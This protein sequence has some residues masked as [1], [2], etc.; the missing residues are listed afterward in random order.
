MTIYDSADQHRQ[1]LLAQDQA[2]AAAMV[3]AY[4]SVKAQLQGDLDYLTAKLASADLA[5]PAEQKRL[6]SAIFQD[7]RVKELLRQVELEIG[8]YAQ[9]VGGTTAI[10]QAAAVAMAQQHTQQL[11]TEGMGPPP[12]GEIS[13]AHLNTEAV[14]DLVGFAA[15]GS[16]LAKLLAPLGPNAADDFRAIIVKT[17]GAGKPIPYVAKQVQQALGVP[18]ARA[19][20]IVRTETLRAYREA[21]HRTMLVNQDVVKGWVWHSALG[22][23]TCASCWALHGSFHPLTERLTDHPNGRCSPVPITRTWKELGFETDIAETQAQVEPGPGLFAKLPLKQQLAIVGPK[24]LA[25]LQSNDI[26]LGD[27][28]AKVPNKDWGPMHRE[29]TIAESLSG[30]YRPKITYGAPP[31][32]P[33][34]PLSVIKT[35]LAKKA[36]ERQAMADAIAATQDQAKAYQK[37]NSKVQS[38]KVAAKKA[39][40]TEP[41]LLKLQAKLDALAAE[42]A[43][44]PKAALLVQNNLDKV[45]QDLIPFSQAA[46]EAAIIADVRG[47]AAALKQATIDVANTTDALVAQAVKLNELAKTPG[48]PDT[49]VAYIKGQMAKVQKLHIR[50]AEAETAAQQQAEYQKA[51]SKVQ[52]LKA[53]AKKAGESPESLEA[54]V[55]QLSGMKASATVPKVQLLLD[56]NLATAID[57][58]NAALAAKKQAEDTELGKKAIEGIKSIADG[59]LSTLGTIKNAL[60]N[61]KGVYTPAV[62]QLLDIELAK[63]DARILKA[64]QAAAA[65]ASGPA[66]IAAGSK[67][68]QQVNSA[69]QSA[70]SKW[71]KSGNG[72]VFAEKLEELKS[73]S[74]DPKA[75]ALI[76]KNLDLVLSGAPPPPPKAA[77][78][79]SFTVGDQVKGNQGPNPAAAGT[80]TVVKVNPDGTVDVQGPT[81]TVYSKINPANLDHVASAP[82][83]PVPTIPRAPHTGDVVE[84]KYGEQYTV[85]KRA[86]VPG[87][88]KVML[89]IKSDTVGI[90]TVLA[91]EVTVV[92]KLAD[93]YPKGTPFKVSYVDDTVLFEVVGTKAGKVQGKVIA[94]NDPADIGT[95]LAVDPGPAIIKNPPPAAPKFTP[96]AAAVVHGVDVEIVSWDPALGTVKIKAP[97]GSESTWFEN[98]V[99]LTVPPT[100]TAATPPPPPVPPTP[101]PAPKPV[102]FPYAEGDLS[103]LN[104]SM[105]GG[106]RK[107]VFQDPDGGKW[108]FKPDETAGLAEQAGYQV[109]HM[110]GMKSPE[111]YVGTIRGEKGSIQKLWDDV[112][113]PIRVDKL[114]DLTPTQRA[115]IQEHQVLDWLISQHDTNNGA[116]LLNTAGNVYA[117]DKGQ[118]FKFL[119]KDKLDWNYQPNFDPV[120]Y[121]H[122]LKGALAGEYE[123]DRAAVADMV[124]KVE[125]LDR[126]L[127]QRVLRPYAEHAAAKGFTPSPETFINQ[128]LER[129]LNIRRDFDDLYDRLDKALGRTPPAPSKAAAPPSTAVTPITQALADDIVRLGAAGRSIHVAGTE[130]E[131]GTILAYTIDAGAGKPAQLVFDLK[132]RAESDSKV[133]ANLGTPSTGPSTLP[134]DDAWPRLLQSIKH[135]NAHMTPGA[136]QFDGVVTPAKVAN[137]GS[138]ANDLLRIVGGPAD[139]A[140]LDMAQ[141]YRAI[142]KHMTGEDLPAI[143][144]ASQADLAAWTTANFVKRTTDWEPYIAPATRGT[145]GTIPTT[146]EPFYRTGRAGSQGRIVRQLN[147]DQYYDPNASPSILAPDHYTLDMG[148]GITAQYVTH[149]GGEAVVPYGGRGSNANG[150]AHQG[151]MVVTLDGFDG[152]AAQVERALQEV[153]R[154]GVK[155]ELATPDDMELLYLAKVARAARVTN[156]APYKNQVT[157]KIDPTTTVAEQLKLH[158]AYWAKKMGVPDVT[159]LPDYEPMPQYDTVWQNG[160]DVG[161]GGFPW[162][163][164][165]DITQADLDREMPNHILGHG[166]GSGGAAGPWLMDRLQDNMRLA[167]TTERVRMAVGGSGQ[168]SGEDQW[169]GGASY[170]FTR[171]ATDPRGYSMSFDK[172]LLRRVDLQSYAGDTYGKADE[173][174]LKLSKHD[175]AGWKSNGSNYGNETNIKNGFAIL[176]YLVHVNT[177]SAFARDELLQALRRHKI[178]RIN[179]RPIE[180]VIQ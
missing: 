49:Q 35:Q 84:D 15:D 7:Q 169:T 29:A 103:E 152:S 86:L 55:V 167:N 137:L 47:Q 66:P 150:F 20:T 164:R 9:M 83:P 112:D 11:M 118:A 72:D 16:P 121:N 13:F 67:T 173:A 51:N 41:A 162:W 142:L 2:A 113:T 19:L 22:L 1:A 92:G 100:P 149:K 21:A 23:R 24:R 6:R 91:D 153:R 148:G 140:H 177:G 134:D 99:E 94:S 62:D 34:E 5:D 159:K 129:Q 166:L 151:R 80:M 50:A 105:E 130:I 82:A 85:T 163:N 28:V 52:A 58:H 97:D 171:I 180:D 143:A 61:S 18:L 154:L 116:L 156:L 37:I 79:A 78:S 102:V 168:S 157:S 69:I 64:Q 98:D 8:K 125:A 65:A 155:A 146:Y 158:R 63:F 10:Q 90:D 108:L 68:Y 139:A 172:R 107:Y 104:V 74:S 81:G 31:V 89:T 25:L 40:N 95:I 46:K 178:T 59:T 165:F 126:D 106:H 170:I 122:L 53:K 33:Y 57:K 145:A 26:E 119:G 135:V 101:P 71:K 14:T 115:Q 56:K 4:L 39:G 45:V 174:H 141:H 131:D 114:A 77:N 44:N 176:D 161:R 38:A 109:M 27:L 117:V 136:P 17:A 70:K 36:A 111:V 179:G 76:Q 48:L 133:R 43:T 96:G 160:G 75:A 60:Q 138:V 87:T 54:L 32:T 175:I 123:L 42:A 73:W 3:K 144:A 110:L 12:S 128:I 132:V 120:A 30:I 124:A 147:N 88:G 93:Q 127:L